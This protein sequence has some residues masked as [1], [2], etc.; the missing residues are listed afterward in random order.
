MS[1]SAE[2]GASSSGSVRATRTLTVTGL[3]HALHDGYTD[4]IY[5]LLPVW[6][7]EFALSY[8]LLALLR[9]LYAGAMAGLQ[10]PVGR[11]A[12]RID[13]KIILIAGTALSALGYVCAGFSGGVIGLGLALAL[14]GAGSSTQHPIASAAVSRAYGA[15]ARGPLGIYNFSGDLGKAA[16]PALTS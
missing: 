12:E 16:I 4:L 8:G 5:V 13:G 9:G 6:Q 11:I 15:G 2:A 7:A 3:N 14:S 10:I 1:V